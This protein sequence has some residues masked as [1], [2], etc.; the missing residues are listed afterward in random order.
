[1]EELL[2]AL[3]AGEEA[4]FR[5]F[6]YVNDLSGEVDRLEDSTAALRWVGACPFG[7]PAVM[8]VDRSD[9]WC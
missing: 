3:A 5:L 4:S 6:S 9:G 7:V 2:G 8:L 1:M